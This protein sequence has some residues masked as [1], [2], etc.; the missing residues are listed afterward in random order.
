MTQPLLLNKATKHLQ[1]QL[2]FVLYNK[3][4]ARHLIGIF[5]RD[6][7]LNFVQDFKETG[8]ILAPFDGKD[9]VLI[10]E[11]KSEIVVVK[12]IRNKSPETGILSIPTPDNTAKKNYE[13]LVQKGIDAIDNNQFHKVVLSRKELVELPD[14]DAIAVFQRLLNQ[15]PTAFTYCFFHPETGLWLGAFAEQLLKMKGN[16]FK[17]MA[18]A[19]TQLFDENQAAVWGT[20]EK[21]EQHFVTNF[22]REKLEGQTSD[23]T[24]SEPYNLQ[25][26][27]LLHIKTDISGTV[28]S[29]SGL[30]EIIQILHPTPAICGLPKETAKD[31]I[32]NNEGYD[33][34]Y[35]SGYFGELNIDFSNNTSATDLYVNL[36]CMKLSRQEASLY[37]GAGITKDSVPEKEWL[38]TVGKAQTMRS[39]L[40]IK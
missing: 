9:I 40:D 28:N 26:G 12:F 2:P 35:Y 19:G 27:K 11:N 5:Q 38:E 29:N 33:R 25:A 20:K 8:F 6:A 32:A 18:V 4:N 24:L 3:P 30:R 17:T 14:Y 31:F 36:R 10:P 34:E 1:N 13:M 39:I 23:V 37:I 7:T 15:Y 22:I 16:S 21:E